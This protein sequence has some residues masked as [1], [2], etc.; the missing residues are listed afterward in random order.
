MVPEPFCERGDP[1]A[2]TG[3]ANTQD[4]ILT[5]ASADLPWD[6]LVAALRPKGVLC[7]LG[8]PQNQMSV[9]AFP[10]LAG[11]KKLVGSNTG[12]RKMMEKMLKFAA[13]HHIFPTIQRYPMTRVN[14]AIDTLR[15]KT[16]RYRAVLE[17]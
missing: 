14:D 1:D 11:H 6:A 13:E 3:A 17:V 8:I 15:D 16:V 7:V 4:L 12:N 2:V 9:A 5:T 10:L